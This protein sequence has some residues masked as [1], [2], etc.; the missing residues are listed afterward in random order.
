M[1]TA[2]FILDRV[3]SWPIVATLIG[4]WYR[5]VIRSIL[6][7]AKIT[8][9]IVGLKAEATI[10]EIKNSVEESL[11]GEPLSIEQRKWLADLYRDGTKDIQHEKDRDNFETFERFRA[12]QNLSKEIT[13][14]LCQGSGNYNARQV[15]GETE[16]QLT[17]LFNNP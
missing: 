2:Q 5:D 15:I 7:G 12:N 13:D 3:V 1:D 17:L 9:A 14:C 4:Y 10:P 11:G 8:L 16:S 6:P